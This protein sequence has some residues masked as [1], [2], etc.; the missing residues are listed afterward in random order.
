MAKDETYDFN[1]QESQRMNPPKSLLPGDELIMECHY[2]SMDRNN[3][4][5]VR[6]NPFLLF[7]LLSEH[8]KLWYTNEENYQMNVIIAFDIVKNNFQKIVYCMNFFLERISSM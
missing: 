3:V 4:T 5:F 2:N 6:N 1:Y 8:K 7:H